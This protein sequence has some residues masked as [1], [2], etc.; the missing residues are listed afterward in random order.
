[1]K[2]IMDELCDLKDAVS[3]EIGEANKRIKNAGGK[4]S[5]ADLDIIDKLAHSMKSLVTVCAMMEADEG[6]YSE[7][8]PMR[9]NSYRGER[10]EGY[11]RDFY[12]RPADMRD[13]MDRM[14]GQR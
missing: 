1:M 6:G 5:T 13:G 3:Y 8:Y 10:R 12:G 4:I 9:G 7:G 14:D 2:Y 11:R